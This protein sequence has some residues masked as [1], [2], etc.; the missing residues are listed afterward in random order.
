VNPVVLDVD[1]D[2][3]A[4]H[5]RDAEDLTQVR[6]GSGRLDGSK[7]SRTEQHGMTAPAGGAGSDHTDF[8]P[9]SSAR[10]EK[11]AD[12]RGGRERAIHR[13]QKNVRVR[14]DRRKPAL[15]RTEPPAGRI[16]IARDG[17]GRGIHAAP[18]SLRVVAEYEDAAH[19]TD[20]PE[21]RQQ[22]LERDAGPELQ[23]R[24]RASQP[25]RRSRREHDGR[26]PLGG[27]CG[28]FGGPGALRLHESPCVA[29][30]VPRG[31]T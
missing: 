5:A 12:R 8:R 31:G 2:V 23:E 26:D 7:R 11:R 17:E 24:L 16:G 19:E 29:L 13:P 10:V 20:F 6:V 18:N 14:R 21:R 25:G 4:R 15:Q 28:C 27:T 22:D 9:R 1:V 3:D 30:F